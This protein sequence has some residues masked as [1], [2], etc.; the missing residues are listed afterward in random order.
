MYGVRVGL[1]G[2]GMKG[3]RKRMWGLDGLRNGVGEKVIILFFL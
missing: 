1:D 2:R 3:V